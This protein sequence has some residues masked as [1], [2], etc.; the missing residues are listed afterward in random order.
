MDI[1][2]SLSQCLHLQIH[3]K[4]EPKLLPIKRFKFKIQGKY[5]DHLT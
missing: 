1:N 3:E 5:D 2:V 4:D